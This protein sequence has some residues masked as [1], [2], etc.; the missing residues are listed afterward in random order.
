MIIITVR[1]ESEGSLFSLP[2]RPP[3]LVERMRPFRTEAWLQT[4]CVGN[5]EFPRMIDMN[6]SGQRPVVPQALH[7]GV[8]RGGYLY[9]FFNVR[10]FLGTILSSAS[11]IKG[12]LASPSHPLRPRE[13]RFIQRK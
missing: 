13:T 10:K 6:S 4:R 11:A 9:F 2:S 8:K 3:S 7:V 1:L 12:A 5:P